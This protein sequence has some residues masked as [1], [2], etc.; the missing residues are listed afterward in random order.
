MSSGLGRN[1]L[2][3]PEGRFSGAGSPLFAVS[4]MSTV[5]PGLFPEEPVRVAQLRRVFRLF[6]WLPTPAASGGEPALR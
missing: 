2:A 1:I 3:A 4:G 6:S 5:A